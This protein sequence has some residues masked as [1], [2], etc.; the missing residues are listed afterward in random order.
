MANSLAWEAERRE[1]DRMCVGR[2]ICMVIG[3]SLKHKK[4]IREK[5][6]ELQKEMAKGNLGKNV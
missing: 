2:V 5:N 1:L 4:A 6:S 3:I